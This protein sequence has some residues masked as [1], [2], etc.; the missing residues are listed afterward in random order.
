MVKSVSRTAFKE[1]VTLDMAYEYID[2]DDSI[3]KATCEERQQQNYVL[4][5]PKDYRKIPVTLPNWEPEPCC[6]NKRYRE[7]D[8]R[9]K[10][11][12]V[13]PDDVWVVTYPKSGTTWCQEMIWLICNDLD[14]ETAGSIKLY[15]RFP[16][17]E[18]GGLLDLPPGFDP[19]QEILSMSSPRFIK[20]HL[21]V[22]LLPDQIWTVRPKMVY[23]RRNPKSVAVSYYH[24]SVSLHEYKG[25][26]DQFLRSFMKELE[27]YSPYHRHVIEYHHLDYQ[28][29]LL[30]LRYEDMKQELKSTLRR[31]SVFFH[32]SY[33]DEQLAKLAQHLSFESMKHNKAVNY[34]E[35][36]EFVLSQ[37]NR[38]DKLRDQNY[39]FIRRGE[40]DGWKRELDPEML[41][42][43]EEW[44]KRIVV[45]P[46]H[47][48]LF[49]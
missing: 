5:K 32:K 10:Y 2:I 17:M 4:V 47:L 19:F 43:L 34:S 44:T 24:H 14:Y 18:L 42:E 23:V 27:Y 35:W 45:D 13:K 28:D 12:E 31:V 8:Q 37:T 25:T 39:M 36:L 48:K 22:A 29:N 49:Q 21:P 46:E 30:H 26:M 1:L 11:M 33:S 9:I 6:L 3:Y 7:V 16:F 38:A 40:A 20:S 41:H 15:N